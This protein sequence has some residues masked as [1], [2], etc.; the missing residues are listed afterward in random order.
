MYI[1]GVAL[2]N[3]RTVA[4]PVGSRVCE[5]AHIPAAEARLHTCE[6]THTSSRRRRTTAAPGTQSLY[7][8]YT[9]SNILHTEGIFLRSYTHDSAAL[10]K[11]PLF[12]S[13]F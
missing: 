10:L 8:S 3:N 5:R 9:G 1:R 4:A 2:I 13:R 11:E 7:G 6:T 12:C